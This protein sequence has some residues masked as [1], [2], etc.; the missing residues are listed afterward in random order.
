MQWV[1]THL[2]PVVQAETVDYEAESQT[3]IGQNNILDELSLGCETKG[4]KEP[5]AAIILDTNNKMSI[6]RFMFQ[7]TTVQYYVKKFEGRTINRHDAIL[8]A[9]NPI[10]AKELARKIVFQ[11][12]AVE[13]NWYN[14]TVAHKLLEQ[15]KNL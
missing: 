4:V 15:I 9:L 3:L 10:E 1:N 5:D 8:I 11:G 13:G 6:G 12:H 7:I 14:C 2:A